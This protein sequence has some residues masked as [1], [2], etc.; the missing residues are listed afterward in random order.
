MEEHVKKYLS[1]INISEGEDAALMVQDDELSE[2]FSSASTV[3]IPDLFAMKRIAGKH[4]RQ[5][6]KVVFPVDFPED[7]RS[8]MKRAFTEWLKPGGS[9]IVIHAFNGNDELCRFVD[10]SRS[11]SFCLKLKK[12]SENLYGLELKKPVLPQN[13]AL[14]RYFIRRNQ[15][16]GEQF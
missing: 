9:L 3:N 13:Q 6:D 12:L 10:D 4:Q 14:K 7:Y 8:I 5:F 2:I 1:S 11:A 16:L 15:I